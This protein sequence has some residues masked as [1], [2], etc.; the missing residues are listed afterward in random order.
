MK[1]DDSRVIVSVIVPI[2]NAEETLRQC[3]DSIMKQT[4]RNF[5][6]ILVNDGSNDNSVNIIKKYSLN[7]DRIIMVNQ[8]NKGV[9]AARNRGIE[10]ANGEWITFVDAD[11]YITE[12]CLQMVL[13]AVEGSDY[14]MVFWNRKDIYKERI[15]EKRVFPPDKEKKVFT[16][17]EL[18]PKVFYNSEGNLELSSCYCRIFQKNIIIKKHIRFFED[19]QYGEDMIFMIDYLK[20]VSKVLRCDCFTYYRTMQEHSAMHRFNPEIKQ[21]LLNLLDH[22]GKRMDLIK[23]KGIEM[24]Y[25]IYM[26]RGPVTGYIECYVCNKKNGDSRRVRRRYLMEFLKTPLVKDAI[27]DISYH[28]LPIRLQIKLFCIRHEILFVL[29]NWYRNKGYM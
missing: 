4:F 9:S 27:E 15:K 18:I 16:G 13:N 10:L 12:D 7:D 22:L 20:S 11:D 21:Y 17:Q 23:D 2:Y 14:E 6:L 8:S 25:S 5:E 3:I 24:S 1:D 19:L 26:F 28:N 29:D